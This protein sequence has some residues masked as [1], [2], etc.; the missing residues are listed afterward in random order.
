MDIL[1][2]PFFGM[3]E[4]MTLLDPSMVFTPLIWGLMLLANLCGIG[5]AVLLAKRAE[6][7]PLREEPSHTEPPTLPK[8]A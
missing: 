3:G 7:R 4:N 1:F 6:R 8:A 5:I 2:F